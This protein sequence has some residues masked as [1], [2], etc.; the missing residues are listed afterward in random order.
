MD[1]NRE[2]VDDKEGGKEG[3]GGCDVGVILH[4]S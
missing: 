1:V 4:G 2:M 3:G